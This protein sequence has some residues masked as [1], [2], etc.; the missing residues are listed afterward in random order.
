LQRELDAQE[1]DL[2]RL[3][4]EVTSR[5]HELQTALDTTRAAREQAE[6]ASQAKSDFL[7]MVSHE[8][9]TPLTTLRI[10]VERLARDPALAAS[11]RHQRIVHHLGES[12]NRLERLI[13][14]LLYYARAEKAPLQAQLDPVDVSAVLHDVIDEHRSQAEGNG[15]T[16]ALDVGPIP[17]VSSDG[18]FLRMI[19]SNLVGNAV[20]FTEQGEVRVEARW[21]DDRLV[22][23]VA[24]TGPGIAPADQARV[25]EPFEHVEP[26]A[27]KHTPGFGLGLALVRQMLQ[28]L[29]GRISL[30]A[31]VGRGSTFTV[32][33]PA[34]RASSSNGSG[35]G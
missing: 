14:S 29:G 3:A 19:A 27:A 13:E 28:A 10:Q 5:K 7:S 34:V 15:L 9:R 4:V 1:A 26:V 30:D 24:D 18:R 16:L 35:S 31:E 20:K 33:L 2:E 17:A 25:F 8:L 32:E 21:A 22:M 11:E 23:T 6:Q 12:S